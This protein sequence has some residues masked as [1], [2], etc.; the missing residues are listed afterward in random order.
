MNE[1]SPGLHIGMRVE[2][3][4]E[5]RSEPAMANFERVV[6]DAPATVRGVMYPTGSVVVVSSQD[7]ARLTKGKYPVGRHMP[8]KRSEPAP[9][10]PEDSDTPSSDEPDETP[11]SE[12]LRAMRA[13]GDKFSVAR[14]LAKDEMDITAGGWDDLIGEVEAAEG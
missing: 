6:L 10:A 14:E 12:R 4:D 13:N 8:F 3:I 2:R 1:D 11:L 9:D 5:I 7:F